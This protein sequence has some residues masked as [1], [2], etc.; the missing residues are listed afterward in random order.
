MIFGAVQVFA[1]SKA[2][3]SQ[4]YEKIDSAFAARSVEQLDSILK[5][6][7]SS[8]DYSSYETYVL[9]K[10][11]S[12]IIENELEFARSVALSVIDNNI[13]NFDAVDLYSYIDK[14]IMNDQSYRYAQENARRQEET[15][16]L[17]N[18]NSSAGK[19]SNTWV[20]W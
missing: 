1:Q 14:A 19:G 10:A 5:E 15:D 9:K 20:F 4:V 12:L 11:H 7:I 13:E 17:T 2:G 16:R 6:N 18:K 3:D 8:S